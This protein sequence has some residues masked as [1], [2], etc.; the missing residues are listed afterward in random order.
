MTRFSDYFYASVP[1]FCLAVPFAFLPEISFLQG[2]EK[3][4]IIGI[5]A[6][7]ILFFA[8]ERRRFIAR[9][10]E[11]L[12]VLEK[13][14]DALEI[15]VTAGNDKVVHLLAQQLEAL[16]EIKSGQQ[17]NFSRMWGITLRSLNGGKGGKGGQNE[18][19]TRCSD[20]QEDV[21]RP[22]EDQKEE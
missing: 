21:F 3:L 16:K 1:S 5:L 19:R 20:S 12:E 9:G 17:E 22:G 11:R 13:R 10:G 8:M 2:I 6:G 14:F 4:G 7:G 18:I 15:K